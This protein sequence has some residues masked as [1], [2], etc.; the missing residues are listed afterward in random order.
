LC[1]KLLFG[2]KSMPIHILKLVILCSLPSISSFGISVSSIFGL[3][4]F[5]GILDTYKD[6]LFLL[7]ASSLSEIFPTSSVFF[8]EFS[9]DSSFVGLS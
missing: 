8:V 9:N 7:N 6:S 2:V 5:I 3:E 1:S 4:V